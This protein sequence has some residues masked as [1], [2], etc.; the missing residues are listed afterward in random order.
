VSFKCDDPGEWV[1]GQALE[2]PVRRRR[3][4][5]LAMPGRFFIKK[6]KSVSVY[7]FLALSRMNKR[8]PVGIGYTLNAY[9]RHISGRD[10]IETTMR[11]GEDLLPY[12]Q[13]LSIIAFLT[14]QGIQFFREFFGLTGAI[15]VT[16]IMLFSLI[17]AARFL[18]RLD[19]EIKIKGGLSVKR[20][21]LPMGCALAF[22]M[23]FGGMVWVLEKLVG[24]NRELAVFVVGIT[25]WTPL[26]V[27][28]IKF[29]T[30]KTPEFDY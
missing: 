19:A 27:L 30:R 18:Q 21:V 20:V 16:M 24:I 10:H 1:E 29:A 12:I 11:A 5:T 26:I 6:V 13:A 14:I 3:Q 7:R 23:V 22:S 25:L 9:E 8:F 15:A 28:N 2:S 17:P 4:R